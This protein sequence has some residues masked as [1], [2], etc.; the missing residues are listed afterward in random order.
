[1]VK[2]LR[3]VLAQLQGHNQCVSH[4]NLVA[5]IAKLEA[6]TVERGAS[7]AEA[8]TAGYLARRLAQRARSAAAARQCALAPGVHVIVGSRIALCPR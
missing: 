8:A 5:K 3:R 7:P 4:Q 6:M 2:Q 1:V